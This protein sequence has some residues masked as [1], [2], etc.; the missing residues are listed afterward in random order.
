MKNNRFYRV[1]LFST[2]PVN[3]NGSPIVKEF[4]KSDLRHAK[5]YAEEEFSEAVRAIRSKRSKAEATF[6]KS[7]LAKPNVQLFLVENKQGIEQECFIR[8]IHKEDQANLGKEKL[9]LERE[10]LETERMAKDGFLRHSTL[11]T[12]LVFFHFQEV[13]IVDGKENELLSLE[14]SL[15][16]YASFDDAVKEYRDPKLIYLFYDRTRQPDPN[17]EVIKRCQ[18][19]IRNEGKSQKFPLEFSPD[20]PTENGL[21][22]A[23]QYELSDKYHFERI[24][25]AQKGRSIQCGFIPVLWDRPYEKPTENSHQLSWKD[26]GELTRFG[27]VLDSIEITYVVYLGTDRFNSDKKRVFNHHD[28]LQA[29]NAAIEFYERAIK[30]FAKVTLVFFERQVPFFEYCIRS[31]NPSTRSKGG[32]RKEKMLLQSLGYTLSDEDA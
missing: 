16:G 8:S 6:S 7:D 4:R 12:D 23:L 10:K 15:T 13:E 17:N 3:G 18:M 21:P 26:Y 30:C 2:S 5:A 28:L 32:N 9:I 24:A 27:A 11:I 1:K 19:I 22:E 20:D 29:R 31:T 14:E 25:S